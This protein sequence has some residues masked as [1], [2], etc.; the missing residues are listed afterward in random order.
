[1]VPEIECRESSLFDEVECYVHKCSGDSSD[2]LH[3]LLVHV[4]YQGG[5]LASVLSSGVR[6]V[7]SQGGKT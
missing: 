1:M 4:L 5:W 3:S 2:P 6:A 7:S